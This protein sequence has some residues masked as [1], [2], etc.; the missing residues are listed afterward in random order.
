MNILAYVHMRNIYRSTGA[1]RVAREMTE[2]LALQPGANIHVLAD[3]LDHSKIIESVGAPWNRFAYHFFKNE[4]S[5]QQARWLIAGAPCAEHYWP[6]ADITYC[7]AESYVPARR[8]R[9]VVTLHDAAIFEGHAHKQTLS[10]WR[11]RI[12]WK[13]LYAQLSRKADLFHTVSEFSA[14]RIAH[15]FPSLRSRLRVVYNGVSER[16]FSPLCASG[17][18]GLERLGLQGKPYVFLPGGLHHRKNADL[19]L[20]AWP[21]LQ[22]R[23]P[24]L[25]LVVGNHCEPSYAAAAKSAAGDSIVFSGFVADPVLRSLYGAARAVWFPSLYEGFGLPILE[26]MASGAPV[27][28]SDCSSMPEIAGGAAVLVSPFD[29]AGHVEAILSLC[30]DSPGREARRALGRLRAAE[31]TWQRS[32]SELHRHFLSVM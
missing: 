17:E 12:K 6:E 10:L 3:P 27:V 28:T 13:L 15:Y 19:I 29:A 20:D 5:S 18:E 8:S 4:T 22:A 23:C 24:G 31:F 1:G 2:Q 16:F 14:E 30:N 7:T 21:R 11:Q 26:A 32:A 25:K 9:L